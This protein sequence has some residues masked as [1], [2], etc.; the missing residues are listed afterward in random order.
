MY[1]ITT[2]DSKDDDMRCVGYFKTFE[3]AEYAVFHNTCDIWETCY[4]YVVI[5]NIKEGLYEYDYNAQ[6]YKWN[7]TNEEYERIE[8]TPKKYKDQIGFAIG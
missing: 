7:N 8:E 4:D 2:I 1:F 5:E 6:W 3:Q